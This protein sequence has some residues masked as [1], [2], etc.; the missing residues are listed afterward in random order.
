[1]EK[2][3]SQNGH[4]KTKPESAT[5][6]GNMPELRTLL[7]QVMPVPDARDL[8]NNFANK[9]ADLERRIGTRPD[10]SVTVDL[11]DAGQYLAFRID[12]S[13]MKMILSGA[14]YVVCI[15]CINTKLTGS[16]DDTVSILFMA[17]DNHMKPLHNSIGIEKWPGVY[18]EH[19]VTGAPYTNSESADLIKNNIITTGTTGYTG[20]RSSMYNFLLGWENILQASV[21]TSPITDSVVRLAD[22]PL[23]YL[24]P[25]SEMSSL[26]TG[27]TTSMVGIFGFSNLE[28][29]PH[30]AGVDKT[31]VPTGKFL[32][33]S[34][35]YYKVSEAAQLITDL[36]TP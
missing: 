21:S 35:V 30:F 6:A 7:T 28:I 2:T 27:S 18:K 32:T 15:Y 16:G 12:L 22:H 19:P 20:I 36:L 8:I 1:M 34:T 10:L 33:P 13:E 4:S 25:A 11:P 14:A 3:I 17:L 23:A 9:W 26:I 5:D 29:V 31:G 24:I